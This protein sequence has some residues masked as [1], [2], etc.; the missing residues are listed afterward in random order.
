MSQTAV[1]QKEQATNGHTPEPIHGGARYT[2]RVDVLETND[3]ILI[4]ADLP[5][6]RPEDVN[7]RYENGQL[8]VYCKCPP[9]QDAGGY[10]LNE[11]GVGDY[12]RAFAINEAI[13]SDKINATLKQGMLTVTL[14]KSVSS[15]P[16]RIAVQV[17]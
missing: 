7:I 9:R 10:L 13:D 4:I 12:Y 8:E 1:A 6:C 2:P 15:A 14:P 3:Q 5:G 17:E 11:Y 16:R